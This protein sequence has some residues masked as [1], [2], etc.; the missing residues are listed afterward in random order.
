MPGTWR[1][2]C[3][4]APCTS[5]S[6][7]A[8]PAP[9]RYAKPALSVATAELRLGRLLEEV[10]QHCDESEYFHTPLDRNAGTA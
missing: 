4:R 10:K 7:P 5:G 1:R 6:F 3:W 9:I 8:S 2:A